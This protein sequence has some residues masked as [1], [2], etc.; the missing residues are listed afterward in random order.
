M[1][2][3]FFAGYPGVGMETTWPR[4]F[5][6]ELDKKIKTHLESECSNVRIDFLG[7]HGGTLV[8]HLLLDLKVPGSKF[9]K[10]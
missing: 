7:K 2:F 3:H 10:D 6:G 8:C 9:D 5:M 4:E 1:N